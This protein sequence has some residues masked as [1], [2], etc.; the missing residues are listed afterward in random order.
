MKAFSLALTLLLALA[1]NSSVTAQE[2]QSAAKSFEQLQKFNRFYRY[3]DATYVDQVDMEPLVEDAIRSMLEDLDPH[4]VYLDKEEMQAERESFDGEFSGIGI[5]YNIMNDSIIVINT[6]VKGPAESVGMQPNDRIVEVDGRNVVGVKRSDVPKLLRGPRSSI[7]RIGVARRGVPDIL[8]FDI[9]RDNIPINTVD[10]AYRVN[11][12]IGYI[13]VNRFG[14]NTMR[15]F[16]EAYEKLGDVKSLILDLSSNGGGMLDPAIEMAGFFLPEGAVVVGTEGRTIPP[17]RYM[18]NEGG[19]FDG[20]VVVLINE[21][22]ASASEIV[23]GALQDWDRAVIVGRNSFG[24]GLVQRQIPLGDG[25]AVRITVARYH[26]PSGRVIQRPYENGHKKEYYEALGGG[27]I[28][29]D[30]VIEPDTSQITD[31]MIDVM[32]KGVYNDFIMSYMDRNRAR[33]EQ[34]YPDFESFDR[35]FSLTDEEMQEFVR[36]AEDKGVKPDMEQFARSRSLITTQ[37][38]A[39]FAQRLFSANEF[40]RYINPRENEYFMRAEEI[41]NNWDQKGAS[42]LGR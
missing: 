34:Q 33:L 38:A 11:D 15:E 2:E 41:L 9:T 31:Y 8:H 13:K 18:A 39:L 21:N 12:D 29:P 36:M 10:A 17:Q 35:G 4:S 24:K 27:G 22:S 32:A 16:Y 3:L 26:T 42:I 37:L 28:S 14:R 5:E 23:A 6:V 7:V 1:V 20:N 40:Y 19:I 25:S 30:I